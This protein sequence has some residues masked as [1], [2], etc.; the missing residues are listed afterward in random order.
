MKEI[1]QD[2]FKWSLIL[3]IAGCIFYVVCPKYQPIAQGMGKFNTVTGS[4]S[5]TIIDFKKVEK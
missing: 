2:V 1:I 4:V 3:I 5:K